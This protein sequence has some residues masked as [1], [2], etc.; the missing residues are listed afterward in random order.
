MAAVVLRLLL[1]LSDQRLSLNSSSA[2]A[3]R[4]TFSLDYS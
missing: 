3:R 2:V 1:S 4:G